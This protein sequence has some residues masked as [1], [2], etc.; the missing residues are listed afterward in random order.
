MPAPLADLRAE[1]R[2]GHLTDD[3]AA[4]DPFA[5]FAAWFDAASRAGVA[6]PNAMTLATASA[7]GR[8]SARIV[9]L[10]GMDDAGAAARG[11]VFYTNYESRKA[12]EMLANARAA[13]C[14]WWEPMERQVRIEGTVQKTTAAESDAYFGV[15]PR[16]SQLGAWASDQSRPIADRGALETQ[17]ERTASRFSDAVPRPPHWGGFRVVPDR[18]EFWQGGAKRLHD[19]IVYTPDGSRWRRERLQ[20]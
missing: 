3:E 6:E 14:F 5:Q 20:P 7:D 2:R 12:T 16:G 17:L 10:K 13:L 11:F 1:Y 15:R 4:A 8:P 9:L 18:A 19:R